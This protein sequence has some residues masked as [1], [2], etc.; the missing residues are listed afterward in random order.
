MIKI[1]LKNGK[2]INTNEISCNELKS[3]PYGHHLVKYA[4]LEDGYYKNLH[5]DEV[6][7]ITFDIK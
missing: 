3:K 2:V 7:N 4:C 5:K 1:N 6:E